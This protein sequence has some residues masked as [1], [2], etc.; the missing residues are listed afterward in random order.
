MSFINKFTSRLGKNNILYN[1]LIADNGKV[2]RELAK[3]L[4][5]AQ[6]ENK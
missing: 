1:F 4:V 3:N 5:K 2:M 6:K